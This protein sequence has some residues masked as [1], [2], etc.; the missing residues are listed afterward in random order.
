MKNK[1][2]LTYTYLHR[3]AF[4]YCV[5][6]LITDPED[7]KEMLKR[8]RKHDLDKSLMYTLIPKADASRIHREYSSHHMENGLE[9]DRYD[10]MEAVIDYE[11]AALTKPDKPLNAYD[12]VHEY[13]S[14]HKKE[15]LECM[16]ELGIDYSYKRKCDF[17]FENYIQGYLPVTDE[18]I[19]CEVYDFA[20][21][22]PQ[23]AQFFLS[24]SRD[25][26]KKDATL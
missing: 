21:M 13:G 22:Y 15:L 14:A 2:Y 1:E 17:E 26:I 5:N 12:T 7:K 8:A 19:L 11:C 18:S 4:L 16:K 25:V 23:E 24:L 6:E 9:K 3:K 10:I 20:S